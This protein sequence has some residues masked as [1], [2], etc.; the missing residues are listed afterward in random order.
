MGAGYPP[1]CTVLIDPSFRYSPL[2]SHLPYG[3][4]IFHFAT[5][6]QRKNISDLS[7]V[8]D[9]LVLYANIR[10]LSRGKAFFQKTDIR[11]RTLL[12]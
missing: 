9:I 1:F 10:M 4:I 11:T 6:S 7:M 5:A 8:N 3:Q 2:L 12:K